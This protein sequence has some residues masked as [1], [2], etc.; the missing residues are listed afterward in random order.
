MPRSLLNRLVPLAEAEGVPL[1]TW[2]LRRMEREIGDVPMAKDDFKSDE[3]FDACVAAGPEQVKF[4]RVEREVKTKQKFD[5]AVV[6]FEMRDIEQWLQRGI[7]EKYGLRPTDKVVLALLNPERSA[8][9][10]EATI[11]RAVP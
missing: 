5:M 11:E 1:N 3:G 4:N 8:D 9:V 6:N 2:M 10:L 7:R